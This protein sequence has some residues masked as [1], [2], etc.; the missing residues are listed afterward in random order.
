MSTSSLGPAPIRQI[1]RYRVGHAGL[2]RS[3]RAIR[4]YV[5]WVRAN[6]PGTL[7]YEVWQDRNDPT[8][9]VHICVFRDSAADRAHSDSAAL[10]KFTSVIG[11]EY[12]APVE[13]LDYELVDTET[14]R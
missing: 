3:L 14:E 1:A 11:A 8:S 6:E 9:F 12:L 10:R 4:E 13:F 5:A 7:H 2:T